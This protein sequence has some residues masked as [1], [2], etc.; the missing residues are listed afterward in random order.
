MNA[1]DHLSIEIPR[2][3]TIGGETMISARN[4]IDSTLEKANSLSLSYGE[5]LEFFYSY[6]NEE[7]LFCP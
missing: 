6:V 2:E 4:N 7:N 1:P 5:R 3:W